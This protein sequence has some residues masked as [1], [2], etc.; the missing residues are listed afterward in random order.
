MLYTKAEQNIKNMTSKVTFLALNNFLAINASK[1]T[2]WTA[3][4]FTA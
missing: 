2:L 3:K 4:P 1:V